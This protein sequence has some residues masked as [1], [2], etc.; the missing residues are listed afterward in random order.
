VFSVGSPGIWLFSYSR[1]HE[2]PNFSEQKSFTALPNGAG[3]IASGGGAQPFP[4][5]LRRDHALSGRFL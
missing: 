3:Q 4:A 1:F 5:D 2:N